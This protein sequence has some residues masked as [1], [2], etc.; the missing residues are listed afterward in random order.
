MLNLNILGRKWKC[1]NQ[2]NEISL[3]K[4][5]QIVELLEEGEPDIPKKMAIISLL[6]GMSIDSVMNFEDKSVERI[7]SKLDFVKEGIRVE[8]PKTFR[9]GRTTYGLVDFDNLSVREYGDM[10]FWVEQGPT[11]FSN[12]HKIMSIAYRPIAVKKRSLKYVLR[13][14]IWR[15]LHKGVIPVRYGEYEIEEL[16]DRHEENAQEFLYRLDFAFGY[17]VLLKLYE[18]STVLRENYSILY[19]TDEQAK[20]MREIEDDGMKEFGSIWGI[21]HVLVSIADSL[22]ERDLWMKR[23]IGELYKYLSYLKQKSI[24]ESRNNG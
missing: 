6:S 3:D 5:I 22:G 21:Y 18:L 14:A 4:G 23:P 24:Y 17:G 20:E 9:L 8:I 13:N 1:P 15:I 7:Y 11:P 10:D 2:L 12:L 16:D 19:P